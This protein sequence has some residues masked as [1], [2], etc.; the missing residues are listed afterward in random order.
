MADK[1][2]I[3]KTN[4]MAYAVTPPSINHPELKPFTPLNMYIA[5]LGLPLF[6]L[7]ICQICNNE[8]LRLALYRLGKHFK[9]VS[10]GTRALVE[11]EYKLVEASGGVRIEKGQCEDVE[12]GVVAPEGALY[13]RRKVEMYQWAEKLEYD[14]KNDS[15]TARAL[16]KWS[17]ELLPSFKTFVNPH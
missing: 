3:E 16:K 13:L 9:P 11:N 5:V 10:V 4:P 14:D 2:K 7:A 1:L 6:L 12:I 15:V 8:R 17:S